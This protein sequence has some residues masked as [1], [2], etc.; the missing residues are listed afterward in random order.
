M[1][2]LHAPFHHRPLATIWPRLHI[3]LLQISFCHHHD[4]SY[5]PSLSTTR[6]EIPSLNSGSGWHAR[7][8]VYMRIFSSGLG[9]LGWTESHPSTITSAP[10]ISSRQG[11]T[12]GNTLPDGTHSAYTQSYLYPHSQLAPQDFAQLKIL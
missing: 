10:V 6:I 7:Q 5:A 2:P 4:P 11:R 3:L 12:V 9:W 8:H 1:L